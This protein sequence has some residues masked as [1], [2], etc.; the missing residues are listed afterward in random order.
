MSL[1]QGRHRAGEGSPDVVREGRHRAPEAPPP[2]HGPSG[3]GQVTEAHEGLRE[4]VSRDVAIPAL[5]GASGTLAAFAL[6]ALVLA[7]PGE[8][9]A[10][11]ALPPPFSGPSADRPADPGG[12]FPE[13]P[14]IT[15]VDW[16]PGP[17]GGLGRSW[18]GGWVDALRE[19][20]RL[21]ASCGT[22]EAGGVRAATVGMSSA[23]PVAGRSST[24]APQAAPAVVP[25][26]PA[27]AGPGGSPSSS[28]VGAPPPAASSGSGPAD[29]P[30]AAGQPDPAPS[31][32]GRIVEPVVAAAEPVTQPVIRAAEPVIRAAEPVVRAAEPVTRAAE[33]V[34][35]AVETAVVEPVT[36]AAQPVTR[37]VEPVVEAVPVPPVGEVV[38][39]LPVGLP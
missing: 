35:A 4:R 33:P 12:G 31:P 13:G 18:T 19:A 24:A 8:P 29:Q 38:G 3:E 5:R 36:E 2:H 7:G 10:W 11:L 39:S 22:A 15:P 28:P 16:Q 6:A 32:V 37:A 34:T 21:A 9:G 20:A 17:G 27:V 26:G 1:H 25:A 23:V 14:A 30:P